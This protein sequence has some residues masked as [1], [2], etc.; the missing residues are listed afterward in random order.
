MAEMM[1]VVHMLVRPGKADEAIAALSTLIEHTRNEDGCLLAVLHRD[2]HD[3]DA[4]LVVERWASRE[5]HDAHL[6][7]AHVHEL[8]EIG[9]PLMAELP[10]ITLSEEVVLRTA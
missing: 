2:I 3:P 5:S 10:R 9:A 8:T 1:V 4:L 6:D 7:T